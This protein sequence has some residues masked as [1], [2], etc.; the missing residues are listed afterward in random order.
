MLPQPIVRA[1]FFSRYRSSIV[2]LRRDQHADLIRA[3][4]G[5]GVLEAAGREFQRALPVGFHPLLAALDHGLGQT[6]RAD[7]TPS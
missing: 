5:D 2:L 7:S 1:I 3:M 4:F 6:I